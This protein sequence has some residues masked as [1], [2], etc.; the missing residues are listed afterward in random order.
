MPGSQDAPGTGGGRGIIL[1]LLHQQMSDIDDTW[2]ELRR[3]LAHYMSQA[4]QGN[5]TMCSLKANWYAF[6]LFKD[7]LNAYVSNFHY[8]DEPE[9]TY[10]E[11]AELNDESEPGLSEYMSYSE[12]D[13]R[14][15]EYPY[16]KEEEN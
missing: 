5:Y 11:Y 6:M 13:D 3:N 1:D 2:W 9:P 8:I 4:D 14:E 12:S 7:V 10:S 16:E 15:Y